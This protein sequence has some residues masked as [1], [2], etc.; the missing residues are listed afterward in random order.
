MATSSDDYHKYLQD[1]RKA[2]EKWQK[3]RPVLLA[4]QLHAPINCKTT[5]DYSIMPEAKFFSLWAFTHQKALREF[6]KVT[7]GNEFDDGEVLDAAN[8]L[9]YK[10]PKTVEKNWN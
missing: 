10:D 7:G 2:F 5:I 8:Y 3:A 1:Q 6:V 4:L 9:W